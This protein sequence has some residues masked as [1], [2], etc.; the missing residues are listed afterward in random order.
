[1]LFWIVIFVD[2]IIGVWSYGKVIKT[3]EVMEVT[4]DVV[5]EVAVKSMRRWFWSDY[6]ACVVISVRIDTIGGGKVG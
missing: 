2:L 6:D 5:V 3:K 4:V 1:M